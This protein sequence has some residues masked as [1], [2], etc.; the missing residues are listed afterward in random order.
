MPSAAPAAAASMA[1]STAG[2]LRWTSAASPAAS[3]L[4]VRRRVRGLDHVPGQAD[5][6]RLR[7]H[8]LDQH[9]GHVHDRGTEPAGQRVDGAVG[10]VGVDAEGEER[11]GGRALG[12][13]VPGPSAGDQLRARP[14]R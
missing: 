9:L 8:G 7:P 12:Q 10:P 3:R 11:P 5:R 2:R 14:A 6:C 13:A 1:A 4:P